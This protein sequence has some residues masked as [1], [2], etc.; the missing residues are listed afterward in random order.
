M[1]VA[2]NA[3]SVRPGVFD[4]AATFT[5]NLLHHLPDA[6]PEARFVVLARQGESRLGDSA[7]L[8][9]RALPVAGAAG[10]IVFESLFA[11]RELRRAG[12]EVLLSPNESIPMGPAPTLVVVAQNLVYHRVGGRGGDFLGAGPLDRL[13]SRVQAAYYRRRMERAY[14]RAAA[15]VAVSDE[16]ARVLSREAGLSPAKT[17]VVP[18]GA[19][20]VLLPPPTASPRRVDR[21]LVVSALAPYKNLERVLEVYA[22]LRRDRPALELTIAGSDWRGYRS[23]LESRAARL[24]LPPPRIEEQV[25]PA[26]L[27]E[28]YSTSRLLLHLS[29]CESFGLP[30]VEAMRY[31]LPV[32]AAARSSLPEVAGG[33]ARLVDPDDV[34][35]VAAAAGELLGS[36]EA[37]NALVA[38]G[39]ARAASLRWSD[40]AAGIASVL[41][42]V[43]ARG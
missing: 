37:W 14:R 16:T 24:G 33:A 15:V 4:G 30:I 21:L 43:A 34:A 42:R 41:R 39:A 35:A 40:T 27:A 2:Y 28:L 29:S 6:L 8:T 31:G 13:R 17:V 18:E 36:E 3:L 1:I 38:S 26:R 22:A 7:R 20:S 25:G 10:R 11:G 19:D 32:V 9:V 23:L 5:L 12:A